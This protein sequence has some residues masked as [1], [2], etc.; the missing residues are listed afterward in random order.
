MDQFIF[1]GKELPDSI[2]CLI[3]FFR[4]REDADVE[5]VVE[6]LWR[7]YGLEF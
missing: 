7:G 5:E 1:W 4:C 2:S 3:L 6:G